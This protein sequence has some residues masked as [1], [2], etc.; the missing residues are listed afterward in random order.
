MATSISERT[1]E[2]QCIYTRHEVVITMIGL[3]LIMFVG[4]L[5]QT[6]ISTVLPRIIGDL[7]GFDLVTWVTT[8]Y[9][10]TSTVTIPIY[11]KLSD[12]FGRKPILLIGISVFLIGSALS[13]ASQTMIQL[14]IFRA[15]QGLGAGAL[16]PIASA[17]VGDLFPP[18]E[19]AKWM[20]VTSC[21]YGAASIAGPI[22][23]GWLTDA[24]SWHW[25]FYINVPVGIIVLGILIFAMP[26]L[27][28]AT[29][30]ISI[31]YLGAALL[32]LGTVPF[33]L[34]F[35]WA[36]KQYPWLSIQV[37][38]MFGSALLFLTIFI[39]YEAFLERQ[40][41]EPIIEPGLF[42]RSARVFGVATLMSVFFGI[43]TYGG[44]LF[45][46]F[47]VQGVIG[48][49]V[50]NTGLLLM[51]F[52]LMAIVGAIISGAM[53]SIFG[54]YKWIAIV[55]V[56]ITIAGF[57]LLLQ[58]NAHST[59]IDILIDM[60]VLGLGI[61]SGLAIYTTATQNALPNNIGQATAAITFFRQIGGS[62]SLAAMGSVMSTTYLPAFQAAVPQAL[63]KA[64]PART[65]TV[66][67]NPD[68]LLAGDTFVQVHA[69]FASQEPQNLAAFEQLH[70]AMKV[71][72]TQGLHNVFL[73]CL[74]IMLA[75][76]I[77]VWFLKELPLRGKQQ[78]NITDQPNQ[79]LQ[80]S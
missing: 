38:G 73:V 42:K 65:M 10:I 30:Q 29:K 31:D 6:I 20:G 53:M 55:G 14:I 1:E 16:L 19:R 57:L 17:V 23:G 27:K 69:A 67:T 79:D 41:R 66:F 48:I 40:A 24:T 47:F 22:L 7:H 78:K 21:A 75:A 61:G 33:L 3:L 26:T 11:G 64:V 49:S 74:G 60:L 8:A 35:T 72:L 32:I 70:E 28:T 39:I 80:L 15:F 13:G 9:L 77:T 56:L 44:F 34:G 2:V 4:T 37:M 58:L 36:G 59:S 12:L 46:P 62:I 45:I 68:N 5:D 54:K 71:A 18:R 63:Q 25:I 51:P 43:V 50:T 76:F 52:M